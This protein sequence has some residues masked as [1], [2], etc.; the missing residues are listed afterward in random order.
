[1]LTGS[2][3]TGYKEQGYLIIDPAVP[4]GMLE[5]LRAAAGRITERTRQGIWSHNRK[6]G[7]DDIWGIGNLLHP[8]VGEPVFARYMGSPNVLEVVA[9]L[10]QVT[11]E[12]S[13]TPLQLELVNMLVNPSIRDYRIGWHRDL[14]RTD[15][16]PEEELAGLLERHHGV[17][18]NT[19]LYDDACLY[20]VPKSHKRPST[21]E[22]RDIVKNR[23]HDPMPEEFIVE[24]KAGQGVYYNPNLMHRGVYYRDRRRETIHACMGTIYGALMR[25]DLYR[26]L[27]WMT[28][29]SVR[30]TLPSELHPF[31]DNFLRMADAT[32]DM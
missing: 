27:A 4:E 20:I 11:T 7:D 31:Y 1:M 30:P 5:E 9:D 25:R 19:A 15:Q 6:A 32:R 10:L 17:Q 29:P 3:I 18:W 12:P 16:P 26:W 13:T 2:Q 24:L 8:D 21:P 23:P 22:E 14:V 28:E